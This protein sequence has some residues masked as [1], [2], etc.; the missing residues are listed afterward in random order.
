MA[1]WWFYG[2][3][4]FHMSVHQRLEDA[5]QPNGMIQS[6]WLIFVEEISLESV[7]Y[8]AFERQP[9]SFPNDHAVLIGGREIDKA[10]LRFRKRR[11]TP[12]RRSPQ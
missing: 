4:K 8:A 5:T 2:F 3:L 1:S 9:A 12:M 7:L 6:P 10:L 11:T